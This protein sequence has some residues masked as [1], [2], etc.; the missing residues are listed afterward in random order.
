MLLLGQLWVHF[1][2]QVD[3]LWVIIHLKTTDP[4]SSA[5]TKVAE[6]AGSSDLPHRPCRLTSQRRACEGLKAIM[7]CCIDSKLVLC[8]SSPL[9]KERSPQLKSQ[10][11]AIVS[12]FPMSKSQ[13]Q[14]LIQLNLNSFNRWKR[15]G[16]QPLLMGLLARMAR[17]YPSKRVHLSKPSMFYRRLKTTKDS[18]KVWC[19]SS[20]TYKTMGRS[21]PSSFI[22]Q[23]LSSSTLLLRE[24]YHRYKIRYSQQIQC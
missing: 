1:C 19:L 2:L 10:R 17:A 21:H 15:Q 18:S 14:L 12:K 13:L 22:L 23:I 16:L 3:S 6:R 4:T 20:Q 11:P 24:I 5:L 8:K 7:M 9:V